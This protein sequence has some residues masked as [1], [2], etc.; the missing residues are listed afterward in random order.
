MGPNWIIDRVSLIVNNSEHS[1]VSYSRAILIV[2]LVSACFWHQRAFSLVAPGR[3]LAVPNHRTSYY[4]IDIAL[5]RM[6]F[7]PDI[8][9]DWG[10]LL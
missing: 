9:G 2:W 10:K 8:S 3:L 7:L 1:S 6:L 4:F 5:L